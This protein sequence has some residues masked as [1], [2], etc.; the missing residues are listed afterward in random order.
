M[1]EKTISKKKKKKKK[2]FFFRTPF[3]VFKEGHLLI[4]G[5][6]GFL[7]CL[8]KI[9]FC[10]FYLSDLFCC[11]WELQHLSLLKPTLAFLGPLGD[12]FDSSKG[13]PSGKCPAMLGGELRSFHGL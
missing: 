5:F 7:R 13:Q 11:C 1:E 8:F 2:L 9:G 6:L 3:W 10:L 4:I 12:D